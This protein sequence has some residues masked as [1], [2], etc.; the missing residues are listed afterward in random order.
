LSKFIDLNISK[1]HCARVFP[2][3][4]VMPK[5]GEQGTSPWPPGCCGAPCVPTTARLRRRAFPAPSVPLPDGLLPTHAVE[6]KPQSRVTPVL[7]VQ[8]PKARPAQ[9]KPTDAHRVQT[10]GAKAARFSAPAQLQAQPME[11]AE[12]APLTSSELT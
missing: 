5:P 6:V 12:E 8:P 2:N 7:R 3:E 1:S 4:V 9:I 11:G 10:P